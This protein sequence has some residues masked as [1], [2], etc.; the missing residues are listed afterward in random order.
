MYKLS[1]LYLPSGIVAQ[2]HGREQ[3][4]W[5][6]YCEVCEAEVFNILFVEHR[7]SSAKL[8]KRAPPQSYYRVMAL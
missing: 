7:Y 5:T 3:E 4:E 1:N 8:F 6:H 2:F